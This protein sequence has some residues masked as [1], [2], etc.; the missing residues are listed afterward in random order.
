MRSLHLNITKAFA[1]QSQLP[2]VNL[3]A[4]E[5]KEAEGPV[6]RQKVAQHIKEGLQQRRG[7]ILEWDDL[8]SDFGTPVKKKIVGLVGLH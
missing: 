8:W 6:A 4:T 1:C 3:R 7:E 5:G 2:K